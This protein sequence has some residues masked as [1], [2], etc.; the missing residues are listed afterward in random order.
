MHINELKEGDIL[1]FS[2]EKGSFIS[3]AITFLTNAP[4]SHAALYYD[5]NKQTII[6]ESPPN[7]AVN[8]AAKRFKGRTIYVQRLNKDISLQPVI[9]HATTYLN[10]LEPYDKTGLYTVGLLLI[11]KKISVETK[12]QEIIIRILKK[13]TASIIDYV[14]KHKTPDKTPMV[15]SQFVAQCYEDAGDDYHLKFKNPVL[16][17]G[18]LSLLEQAMNHLEL[19]NDNLNLSIKHNSNDIPEDAETLCKA[20]K[21][22]LESSELKLLN[23]TPPIEKQLVD[24]I[25]EFSMQCTALNNAPQAMNKLSNQLSM[26]VFP[27]DL[28]LHCTNTIQIGEIKS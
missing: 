17:K 12:T 9:N 11:Y 22:S 27:G 21:E 2:A 15:C 5:K 6:E 16:Q 19:S 1:L 23:K 14:H 7:I 18:Q 24:A 26:Y 20:L 10:N 13:L 8:D 4:V 28:L 3:W 25:A